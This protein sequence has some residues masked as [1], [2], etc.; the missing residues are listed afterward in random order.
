MINPSSRFRRNN[1]ETI[2]EIED[3][4][5]EEQIVFGDKELQLKIVFVEM[6]ALALRLLFH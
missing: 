2:K 3:W 5:P 6:D 1:A 4:N